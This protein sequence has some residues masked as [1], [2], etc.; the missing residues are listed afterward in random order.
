MAEVNV[1]E[2]S[3]L[4]NHNVARVPVSY[5]QN[6]CCNQ[7]SRTGSDEILFGFLQVLL[8]VVFLEISLSGFLVKS[9]NSFTSIFMNFRTIISII[10]EF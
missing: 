6:K 9:T 1:K 5:P 8:S 2:F 3:I 10:H 7:V 4:L